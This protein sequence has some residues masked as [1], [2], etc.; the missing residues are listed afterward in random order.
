MAVDLGRRGR[1]W[2]QARAPLAY[3]VLDGLDLAATFD[4][5]VELARVVGFS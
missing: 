3:P 5:E 1:G 2:T 4:L